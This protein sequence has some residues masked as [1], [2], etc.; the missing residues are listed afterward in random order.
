M[1]ARRISFILV[2]A[3]LAAG[4]A[5][6]A[7]DEKKTITVDGKDRE[8]YV[9]VPPGYDGTTP[10]P[11]VLGLHGGGGTADKF[12][13]LSHMSATADAHGF[14][15]VYPQGLDKAWNDGR[16][17]NKKKEKADDV[18]FLG[19]LCKQLSADYAI[20]ETRIYT[21]GISNGGFMSMRL[22]AEMP[23][24]FAAACSVAA[25]VSDYLNEEHDPPIAPI[26][27][28]LIN[29]TEDPLVPY[30]GGDVK[31]LGFKRGK[32]L[33]ASD[34]VGWWAKY[35]GCDVPPVKTDLPDVDPNDGITVWRED[36][37]HAGGADAVLVTVEGGGH[38]WPS[39]WQYL[40]EGF[41]GKTTNDI[42]NEIIWTFFAAHPRKTD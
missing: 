23:E 15:A 18:K 6:C 5:A 16:S 9:H 2:A 11:L 38:T 37:S 12:D 26:A 34:G 35:N 32:V 33:S 39:G 40:G 28:M 31:V 1:K 20:D 22:A 42:D 36:Y 41:I 21:T 29:G 30:E 7:K 27:V 13:K 24:V 19:E 10:V 14:I 8:Y 4:A 3:A 25:G 17:I